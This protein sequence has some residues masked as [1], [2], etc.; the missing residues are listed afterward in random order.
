VPPFRKDLSPEAEKDF[1]EAVSKK[2][3]VKTLQAGKDLE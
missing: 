3:Q 1:L 2:R